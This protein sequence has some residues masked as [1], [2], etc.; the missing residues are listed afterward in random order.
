MHFGWL[1]LDGFWEKGALFDFAWKIETVSRFGKRILTYQSSC[2]LGCD[3]RWLF[4]WGENCSA[5]PTGC[6]S[7]GSLNISLKRTLEECALEEANMLQS[8]G[9]CQAGNP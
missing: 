7:L 5:M 9:H 1:S 6:V 8:F 3:S 4:S 2:D